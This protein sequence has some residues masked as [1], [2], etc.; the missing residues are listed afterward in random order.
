MPS[1]LDGIT[2]LDL[3]TGPAAALATML[4]S[5]Q[6]ARVI[7]VS[8]PDAPLF[9]DGGFIIWDRGKECVALDLDQATGGTPQAARFRELVAAAD[10]LVEDFAPSSQH[11]ELVT[12]ERLAEIN[13]RL[14]SCS[15]TAYGK[16]GALKDEPPIEDLVLARM[17]VLGGLPGF[18][19]APVHLVHPL[20]TVGAAILACL[21]IAAALLARE[22]SGRGRTVETSLMAGALLYHPKVIGEHLDRHVFQTHPSGSAPFY[23]VYECADGNWVQLGC[24]H[25]GFIAIA[26]KLMGIGDL[27]AEPRFNGGGAPA[28]PEDDAELRAV[29]TKVIAGKPLA[30][31][32]EAFEAADVP[33]AP[34]R[35]TKDGM[36]DPQ[37]M[38]NEMVTTLDDPKLGPVVQMGVPLVFSETPGQM[39]G[40]RAGTENDAG[41]ALDAIDASSPAQGAPDPLPLDGIRILEITNLIAGPT[42]GRLLADLGADVIKFEPLGGDLSRPIGRTYFYNLNF[43]KRSVSVNTSTD[44]GKEVVQRIAAAS[45][46]LLANLRPGATE[47]MGI[48]PANNPQLIETHLTGYGRTGPYA[49]RPGIDPLAQAMMGMSWAQGGPENQ[50]VF[51]AQLAPTDYTTGALGAL[52]TVLAIYARARHGTVQRV[53][54]NLL[55]GAV[56]LSSAWFSAYK[57]RPERPLADKEQ[58]GVNPFH[59][60][61]RLAD[62]WIYVA[63]ETEAQRLALCQ[64]AGQKGQ[65]E[66]GGGPHP[67][68]TPLA[69]ALAAAFAERSLAALRAELQDADVPSAEA[70]SGDSELYL[71]DPHTLA[72]AMAATVQHPTAGV[73]SVACQY[74]HLG[75]TRP[76]AW[77]P[78]PLLGEHTDEALREV[79]YAEA[80]IQ[81][82]HEAG[83]IKTET[84]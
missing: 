49:H 72:N 44:E 58:Y 78:T 4:L 23:S 73:L 30:E 71:D 43:N 24:V 14:I 27:V 54:S 57:G 31:W 39:K 9:R 65:T 48:G 67:N 69:E 81:A 74:I 25:V 32:V 50:P 22:T 55:N 75:N 10:I 1:I 70:Q 52:G 33:F 7:R 21:G 60:L 8:G 3:S 41:M 76:C 42:G 59:R 83:I 45:D 38:H 40:P 66:A 6:G 19:P 15:V 20:P 64:I 82:L 46:A 11:Q 26:A 68:Q 47:R 61:F 34:A 5:D 17:G 53:D 29:L 36:T 79:G 80:D 56:L 84:A 62:G 35:Q 13:P 63:A 16:R 37:V 51:P 28:T 2:I 77:R 18:R 12:A